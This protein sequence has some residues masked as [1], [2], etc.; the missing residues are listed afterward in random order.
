MSVV[1]PNIDAE[2]FM[3]KKSSANEKK[4]GNGL[5]KFLAKPHMSRM[6]TP[7]TSKIRVEWP[8]ILSSDC[9]TWLSTRKAESEKKQAEK[10]KDEENPWLVK[11]G[12]KSAID[13]A[14]T[15]REG[16][17]RAGSIKAVENSEDDC[18][19]ESESRIPLP[20][21]EE[22]TVTEKPAEEKAAPQ[23]SSISAQLKLGLLRAG[24]VSLP[25]AG[26]KP[27][28]QKQPKPWAPKSLAA[29]VRKGLL[30]AGGEFKEK[31]KLALR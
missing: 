30:S 16:L 1:F 21:T 11:G 3:W 7:E 13:L 15:V 9:S 26:D 29:E 28:L 4:L 23:P 2:Q 22:L 12:Q 25:P 31:K 18:K 8:T 17:I 27:V 20:M 19:K 6:A 14:S 10:Q 24:S 5:D